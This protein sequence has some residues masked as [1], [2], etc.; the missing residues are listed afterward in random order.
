MIYK[1]VVTDCTDPYRNLAAEQELMKYAAADTAILFL[2]QNENTIVVGR[3]QDV[4]AECRAEEFEANHGRVARR[5]SGG[6][7][8]FHD[9]GNLN[10]SIICY[11]AGK[12]ACSY[13]Q[14][15]KKALMEF[16]ITAEYN[17]RNDLV[18]DGRKFSGNAAYTN[19]RV[20][21]QHGTLLISSDIEKMSYYLTP[22]RGKME[23]NHVSSVSARVVNLCELCDRINVDTMRQAIIRASKAVEMDYVLDRREVDD[24]TRIYQS[25]SWIYG[26]IQ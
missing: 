21:C 8:V 13:Q 25:T 10:F 16:S 12:N 15:M 26:G 19:E 1:Y 6:G 5:R 22:E 23:R 7:A 17:G 2:W 4:G 18:V 3:N 14:L 24:L 11:E 20:I 9:L